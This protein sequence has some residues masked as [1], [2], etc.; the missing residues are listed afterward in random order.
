VVFLRNVLIYFRPSDVETIA[1]HIAAHIKPNGFLFLGHSESLASLKTKFHTVGNSIYALSPRSLSVPKHS[2]NSASSPQ[3]AEMA[4]KPVRVFIIDDSVT[5]RMMLRKML[6]VSEG[7]E[8]VGEAVN[9]IEAD[10]LMAGKSIDVITLD[11]HMPEMDGITYLEKLRS[12]A[13]PPVVM[14]SSVSY[15]DAVS[16][17][18][19]FELGAVDYIE[20]PSQ[21]SLESEA[22]R[23][24]SVLRSVAHSKLK[25]GDIAHFSRT[26]WTLA[27]EGKFLGQELLAIGAS[28]GGVEALQVVLQQMPEVSPPI[29]IV[30]HIPKNFSRALAKRLNELCRILVKEAE[31]GETVELST[32]Y[33]AP[34][35]TQMRVIHSGGKLEIEITDD[36]PVNRHKPSV[37]YMFSSL[38][39]ISGKFEISA[40]ILTGM[41]ADG[42][43]GIKELFDVGAHTIAQDEASCVVF[44]MPKEAIQTGGVK[45]VLPLPSIAYHMLKSLTKKAAA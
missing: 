31:H 28:T 8:V 11:I 30:Q 15:D 33:I 38:A 16:A 35:A 13:H 20:K 10:K 40:A 34:G 42:A 24:R 6:N 29:L 5:I 18:K 22:D 27:R 21:S 37:D 17:M 45:E 32:A 4:Q 9:P 44:G 25:S 41:G 19:C 1:N 14:V 3:I 26:N 7:F 39:K 12:R 23:V 2:F 43:Q 36:A